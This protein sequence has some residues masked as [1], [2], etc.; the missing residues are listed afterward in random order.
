MKNQN[1]A[2]G[3]IRIGTRGSRLALAQAEELR[4][5]LAA[6]HA[7]L[8]PPDA[9]EIVPITTTGDRV[10]DR[11]LAEIGGKGL[12]M[13]EIE[14]ALLAGSIDLALHSMKDVETTLT[15]GTSIACILPREEPR[16]A[17]LSRRA[18]SIA[19]LPAGA[20]VGTSSVRRAA[21]LRHRRS[22]L[23]IVLFRGN[24]DTR[25][26]KL[27][28]GVVDATLLALCGLKRLGLAERA[29]CVL[30]VE[31]MPPAV[32]QGALGVQ[33][34]QTRSTADNRVAAWLAAIHDGV[35]ASRIEAERAMLAILDGSCRTPIAGLADIDG[36]GT[37]RL[38]GHVATR[39]GR[40]LHRA[41]ATGPVGDATAIGQ[42]V[43]RALLAAAGTDPGS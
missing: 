39:D 36:T 41:E 12:F 35:S 18:A 10:R 40:R 43:G 28:T 2:S 17:L 34:R 5:R 22:D 9:I 13:K 25:L 27:E 1:K 42:A 24:V 7:E 31:D 23:E 14:N 32:G 38:V 16:D 21:L 4:Q 37:L 26:A 19:E 15:P 6:A 33:C 29:T 8:R 30:D 11:P 20:V 3:L